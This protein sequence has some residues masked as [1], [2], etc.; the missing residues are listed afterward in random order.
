[1]NP[2]EGAQVGSEP[3][4]GPFTGIAVHLTLAIGIVIPRP[5]A[6]PMTDGRMGRMAAP[7]ALPL[8]GI[9]L[10]AADWNVVGDKATARSRVGTV[11]HPEAVLARLPRHHTDDGGTIVGVGPVPFALIR[12]A[13]WRIGGVAMRRAFF[14]QRSDTAHPPQMSC[15]ASVSSVRSGSGCLAPVGVTYALACVTNPAR[16]P[17]APLARPWQSREAA[18]PASLVVAASSRTR[19]RSAGCSTHHNPGSGRQEKAL[20]H[21]RRAVLGCHSE[22]M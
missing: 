14:P 6:H 5:F 17:S 19:Y 20:V 1:M 11:A 7:V 8:V 22:S 21:E 3:R 16:G 13:T 15:R 2:T 12:S 10:G 4:A 9:E 18:A